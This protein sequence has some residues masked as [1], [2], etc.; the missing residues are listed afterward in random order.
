LP[1]ADTNRY[2]QEVTK[3]IDAAIGYMLHNLGSNLSLT[4]L[5][6]VANYSPFH[7]HKLF[8]EAIGVSPKQYMINLRLETALHQMIIHPNKSIKEI[9]IECGYSS[10]AIFTR[11]ISNYFGL[12]PLIIRELSSKERMTLYIQKRHGPQPIFTSHFSAAEKPLIVETK[13]ISPLQGIHLIVPAND[14]AQIQ[15]MFCRLLQIARSHDLYDAQ[16]RMLGIVRP[17]QTNAYKVFISID[18]QKKIPSSLEQTKIKPGKYATFLI[19]GDPLDRI[20]AAHQFLQ[21]WLPASGYKICDA[22]SF[23]SFSEDPTVIPYTE[24]DRRFYVPIEPRN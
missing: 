22:P 5:S 15:Y 1:V 24:P 7:F 3:R 17:H 8:K 11:A 18:L 19:K 14:P 16:S 4:T 13:T 23:E 21:Q 20:S 6:R 2:Q 9:S 10:P 12:S